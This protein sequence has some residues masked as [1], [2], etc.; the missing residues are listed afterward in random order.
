MQTGMN[1]LCKGIVDSINH[2]TPGGNG[3][4]CH[5]ASISYLT[6]VRHLQ[7]RHFMLP[8]PNFKMD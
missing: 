5:G 4:R 8:N 7:R 6:N 2:A 1:E 3:G